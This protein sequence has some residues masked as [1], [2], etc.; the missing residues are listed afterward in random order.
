MKQVFVLGLAVVFVAAMAACKC[1]QCP[2]KPPAHKHTS[3]T[4]D[5]CPN[6]PRVLPCSRPG[7]SQPPTSN[8]SFGAER[9]G[10]TTK[11]ISSGCPIEDC[12]DNSAF[13]NGYPIDELHLAR[14]SNT[15]QRNHQKVRIVD[16]IPPPPYDSPRLR[17]WNF[18]LQVERGEF[19]ARHFDP[20]QRNNIELR[21]EELIG[22]KLIV[23]DQKT[24]ASDIIVIYDYQPR[25]SWNEPK[26]VIHK[27]LLTYSPRSDG[28]GKDVDWRCFTTPICTVAESE[29]AGDLAWTVVVSR[30]RYKHDANSPYQPKP[31]IV[32]AGATGWFNIACQ[33]NALYKMKM[34]GY[35]PEPG[36][37]QAHTVEDERMATLRMITADY[38]GDDGS[39]TVDGTPLHWRN[40]TYS[41]NN[42]SAYAD[43]AA[44][45][46]VDDF[47][48]EA[49]WTHEGAKCLDEPRHVT[50]GAVGCSLPSCAEF[51][52]T[53][54]NRCG[55]IGA[56]AP[57][58]WQTCKPIAI[59][60]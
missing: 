2:S 17:R 37:G 51:L 1:P 55:D 3:Q 39:Y 33:G 40:R 19:V 52:G 35:D 45:L 43:P 14:G 36:P 26:A 48:I 31:T 9:I 49:I 46:P 12:G 54:A 24:G 7:H 25:L 38:C 50:T 15:G 34:M 58:E 32:V 60:P 11:A 56:I 4:L 28:L 6:K 16:F 41:V 13:I 42:K 57:N 47:A 59:S 30:E 22:S 20:N 8:A 23:E 18:V 5:I 21:G 29:W 53:A 27:Y 44:W 10:Q